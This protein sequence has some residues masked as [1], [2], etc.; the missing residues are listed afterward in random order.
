MSTT[1]NLAEELDELAFDFRT[2]GNPRAAHGVIKEPSTE[3]L[4]RFTATIRKLNL[5]TQVEVEQN[6]DKSPSELMALLAAQPENDDSMKPLIQAVSDV[7][8]GFPS[9]EDIASLPFRAQKVFFGWITGQLLD[10][11]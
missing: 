9:V 8:S 1:F 4:D 5:E 3:Q 10:P 2:K 11:K 6:K 7:C